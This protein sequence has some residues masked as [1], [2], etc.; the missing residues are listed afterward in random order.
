MGGLPSDGFDD[1]ISYKTDTVTKIEFSSTTGQFA[2]S[3]MTDRVAAF[4]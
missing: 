1:Y 3:G 4:F 2:T